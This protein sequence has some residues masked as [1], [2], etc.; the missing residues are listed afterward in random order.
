M[1]LHLSQQAEPR[2]DNEKN[3]SKIIVVLC[4]VEDEYTQFSGL[5]SSKSEEKT[6]FISET[7]TQTY[8][9][10]QYCEFSIKIFMLAHMCPVPA[11]TL[12]SLL[13][14]EFNPSLVA[15][16]G[17]C[18]GRKEK[19]NLGDII[20][21]QQTHD[22]TEGR[23]KDN[24]FRPRPH[25]IQMT[26]SDVANLKRYVSTHRSEIMMDVTKNFES[27]N[28]PWELQIHIKPMMCSAMVVDSSKV[29]ERLENWQGDYHGIEMESYGVAYASY[30]FNCKWLVIKGVQDCASG[31]KSEEETKFKKF[32]AYASTYLLLKILENDILNLK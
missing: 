31:T 26:Q 32:G 29:C 3:A 12:T 27:I 20:I 28:N 11:A 10:Y 16:V 8:S 7:S 25:P 24:E 2:I 19:T 17:I 22:F 23:Y 30:F 15:M 21:A 5:F 14:K 18:A 6:L 13:I 9:E 1:M 4:A